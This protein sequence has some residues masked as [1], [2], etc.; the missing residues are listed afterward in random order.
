MGKKLR[1]LALGFVIVFAACVT[2]NIYFPAA[3]IQKAADEIVD[4]VRGTKDGKKPEEKKD[5]KRSGI[6]DSLKGL[7]GP[8]EASAQI[9][10]EVS[11]PAI[12]SIKQAMKD[13]FPQIKPFYDKGLVGENNMGLVGIKAADLSLKDKADV[14]RLVDAENKNRMALYTEIMKA[15]KLGGDSLPKIQKLFANSWRDKSQPGWWIQNE[16]GGWE[17]KK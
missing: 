3:A 5:D 12:R 17:K 14:N 7:I 8:K 10:V 15:N 2:V 1:H 4:D 11:T 9:N 6:I 16:Q 13:S